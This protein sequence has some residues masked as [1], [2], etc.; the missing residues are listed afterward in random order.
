[1]TVVQEPFAP[2]HDADA[3]PLACAA[4]GTPL[5]AD[6]RYCL[7]CGLRCAP[8]ELRLAALPATTPTVAAPALGLDA[9]GGHRR[10]F[11]RSAAVTVAIV[12]AFGVGIGATIGPAAVGETAAAQRS[13]IVL[14]AAS[15][16]PASA[17]PAPSTPLADDAPAADADGA[18]DAVTTVD[19]SEPVEQPAAPSDS[20]PAPASDVPDTGD[21]PPVTDP[22]DAG[23]EEQPATDVAPPGSKALAG[24]VVAVAA[25][26]EGFTL[27][28]RGGALLAVHASGCGVALGDDLHLRART[29]A[30]GT[31][32]ADRIRRVRGAVGTTRVAGTVA[33]VDP[34]G[35]R[36][37]LTARG[38]TL[39]VTAAA[40]ADPAD[41]AVA[42]ADPAAAPA[43]PAL[44]AA[45]GE[46]GP[47]P[48]PVVGDRL[49]ASVELRPQNG[50]LPAELRERGRIALASPDPAA[51]APAPPLELGGVV[52]TVDQ[53][54]RSV[55]LALDALTPPVATV[56]LSVPA[57]LDLARLLPAQRIAATATRAPDG[58]YVLSGTSADGDAAVADD[59]STT[60]GD[61][62]VAGAPGDGDP[63]QTVPS[64]CEL[65]T[66]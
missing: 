54:A 27:A 24:V 38:A 58:T 1:M 47:S 7:G 31:W 66:S 49:R 53:Q 25:D 35:G 2:T 32:A 13:T 4:C 61:Q 39:L 17:V 56:T 20:D 3:S 15:P 26:G 45:T 23:D 12:L 9:T 18:P 29:L 55:V 21:V 41:P 44:A 42:P 40:P 62:V 16:A 57:A 36:Y 34:A 5:D 65:L 37:A 63:P 22:P 8:D 11:A 43:D 50:D 59:A 19:L 52:V 10:P 30:N 60:Q 33:W 6:Q 51:G 28:D 46:P 48:L 64:A 14:A